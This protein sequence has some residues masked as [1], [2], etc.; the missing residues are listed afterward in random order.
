M[1][2]DPVFGKCKFSACH[3]R[4][5]DD[6]IIPVPLDQNLITGSIEAVCRINNRIHR[7]ACQGFLTGGSAEGLVFYLSI[8]LASIIVKEARLYAKMIADRIR[9]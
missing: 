8:V 2:I 7:A 6:K 5:G 3:S 4:I 9:S 1:R